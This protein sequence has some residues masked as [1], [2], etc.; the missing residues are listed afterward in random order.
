MN[1]KTFLFLPTSALF[2]YRLQGIG[3]VL[4]SGL[5][6]AVMELTAGFVP[7]GFSALQVVWVRYG[8]HLIF[9]LAVFGPR[10]RTNL[11]RTKALRLQLFRPVFM[12][13]MPLCFLIG[14]KFMPFANVWSAFWIAPFMTMALAAILLQERIGILQWLTMVVA[15]FGATAIYQPQLGH[16]N[17][18]I[19]FPLGM[20]FCFSSYLILTRAL[21]EERRVT[22]LLYSALIVFLPWSIGFSHFWQ[23]L[24]LTAF[25][26]MAAIGILGFWSLYFLDKAYECAPVSTVTPFLFAEPIFTLIFGYFLFGRVPSAMAISGSVLLVVIILSLILYELLIEKRSPHL[27]VSEELAAKN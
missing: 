25:Y 14:L 10:Y 17:W 21:R 23:P 11:I 27:A 5:F 6:W 15:I 22:N 8:T 4:L 19:I 2:R 12:I 26:V 1:I 24:N 20:A 9:M 16:F 13:G 7:H 18:A 3:F